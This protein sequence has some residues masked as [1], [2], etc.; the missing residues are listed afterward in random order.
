MRWLKNV[1]KS[2]N[3][4]KAKATHLNRLPLNDLALWLAGIVLIP[5]LLIIY[6]VFFVSTV[7][8]PRALRVMFGRDASSS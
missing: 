1:N 8:I 5:L 3:G 4:L 6:G 2:K 7:I